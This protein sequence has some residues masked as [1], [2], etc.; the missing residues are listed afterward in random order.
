M[1]IDN[2]LPDGWEEKHGGMTLVC[3][4]GNNIEVDGE[5]PCGCISPLRERG[6]V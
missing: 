2:I 4:H 5:G 3:P 1:D 6:I